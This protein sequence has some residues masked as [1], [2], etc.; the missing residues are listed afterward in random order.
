MKISGTITQ[1]YGYGS[2]AIGFQLPLFKNKG[3][4]NSDD[5][6]KG[7]LNVE[8]SPAHFEIIKYDYLYE[9]VVNEHNAWINIGLISIKKII[10]NNVQYNNPGYI[11]HVLYNSSNSRPKRLIEVIAVKLVGKK[12]GDIVEIFIPEGRLKLLTQT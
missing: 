6:V 1:G 8:I 10:H 2:R 4:P 5:F 12:S 9:N 11:Y 3:L 7:T